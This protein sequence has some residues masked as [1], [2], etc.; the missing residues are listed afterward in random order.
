MEIG[1]LYGISVGTGDPELL[2][3]KGLRLLQ[4]SPIVAFPE[5][6]NNKKGMA[7]KIISPWLRETQQL[8][9]LYFPYVQDKVTLEKAWKTAAEQVWQYL[10]HGQ[11]VAYVCEG[12]VSFYSTFTNLAQKLTKIHSK[13]RVEAIPGVCSPLAAAAV[14]DLPLT[15]R[16]QRLAVLPALY[17]VAEFK[18]VLEWADVV[19]LM[20]MA[21]VYREVWPILRQYNLLE[22]TWIVEKATST[23]Q[24][25]YTNLS[26]CHPQDLSYFSI[27]IVY[28]HHDPRNCEDV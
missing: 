3:L 24:V 5:G 26:E 7:Q 25:I 16:S 18:N 9:P 4:N 8:L 1:T 14:L 27:L 13:A 19:V 28:V 21:S 11:D 15:V 12:D 22:R 17:G 2:T 23:E 6:V 20:K 10:Q